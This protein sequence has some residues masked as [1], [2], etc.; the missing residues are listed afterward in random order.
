MTITHI[1]WRD[2]AYSNGDAVSLSAIGG[3]TELQEVG[4]L[5]AENDEAVTLSMESG[6]TGCNRCFLT[7]PK[8]N[9]VSRVDTTLAKAFRL[10][11]S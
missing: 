11:R 4:F 3:L 6:L 2:A 8:V 1:I 7:V 5:V 10:K 9:I